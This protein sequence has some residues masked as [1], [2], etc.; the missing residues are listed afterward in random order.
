MDRNQEVFEYD[1]TLWNSRQSNFTKFPRIKTRKIFGEHLFERTGQKP[2]ISIIVFTYRR[3]ENLRAALD[4][5]L[6]Q[7]YLAHHPEQMEILV[8]DDSGA[9]VSDYQATE[10][11]MREYCAIHP[12]IVYYRHDRNMGEYPNWNR[13]I[14]R[15]QSDYGVLLHDDIV[16]DPNFVSTLVKSLE[17][18][19]RDPLPAAI[20]VWGRDPYGSPNPLLRLLKRILFATMG[21][22]PLRL[23]AKNSLSFQFPFH[24]GML[25]N[26]QWALTVGGAHE[27]MGESAMAAKLQFWASTYLLPR[28][29]LTIT[30]PDESL[31][32]SLEWA[33]SYVTYGYR[34]VE[35]IAR[36]L[37]KTSKQVQRLAARGAMFGEIVARGYR[38]L[39]YSATKRA[40]GMSDFYCKRW[41]IRW[42]NLYQKLLWACLV[43]N[44]RAK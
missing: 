7:D 22:R 13:A 34:L 20:G 26:R 31:S 38:N 41:V 32:L 4:S 35:A 39:D 5:A 17:Y 9:E 12:E 15:C 3:P 37:G 10:Q 42:Y 1:W 33:Y 25:V 40:L 6:A 11:V 30:F 14:E 36:T 28:E 19:Q 43:F 29:L 21:R 8:F 2:Q 23:S 27:T 44:R 18:F 24:P 16:F